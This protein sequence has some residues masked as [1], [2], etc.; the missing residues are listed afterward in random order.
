MGR[1]MVPLR[2]HFLVF[3]LTL[4]AW[5]AQDP[6]LLAQGRDPAN[7]PTE[8]ASAWDRRIAEIEF[9]GTPLNDVSQTLGEYFPEINFV[10]NQGA[11]AQMVTMRLHQVTLDELLKALSFASDGRI[12]GRKVE[13]RLV[14]LTFRQDRRSVPTLKAFHLGRYLAGRSGDEADLALQELELVLEISWHMLQ[15]ADPDR[16]QITRPQLNIHRR[17]SLLIAVGQSEQLEVIAEIVSALQDGGPIKKPLPIG[18]PAPSPDGN[19]EEAPK[20]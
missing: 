14:A 1:F 6:T 4:A 19:G 13:D 17:T 16:P 2:A 18:S 3:L 10:V 11:E 15:E 5:L 7:Q 8:K 9:D 12:Q 20:R